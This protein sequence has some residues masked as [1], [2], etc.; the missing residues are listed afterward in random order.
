MSSAYRGRY[1][2]RAYDFAA[3]ELKLAHMAFHHEDENITV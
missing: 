1:V 3:L 2:V